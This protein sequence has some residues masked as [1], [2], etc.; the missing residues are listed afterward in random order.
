[1]DTIARADTDEIPTILIAEDN[2]Q[3]RQ[4]L[5]LF[6]EGE[7]Y[8]VLQGGNGREALEIAGAHDG[9]IDV[10]ISDA[11]MPELDGPGL[12][13][14]IWELRP[15]VRLIIMSSFSPGPISL[16]GK[17]RFIRK[18]FSPGLLLQ[19]IRE[20]LAQPESVV[21]DNPPEAAGD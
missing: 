16:E 14:R 8:R 2:E 4:L 12:V 5:C 7:G 6:L 13:A 21:H 19:T 1:M 20:V 15:Q 11:L 9:R 10:L 17:W 3:L 18:P